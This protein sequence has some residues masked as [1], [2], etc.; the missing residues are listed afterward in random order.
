MAA[1]TFTG[2]SSPNDDI[3]V[4]VYDNEFPAQ[5]TTVCL[6]VNRDPTIYDH[7]YDYDGN[8]PNWKAT[9]MEIDNDIYTELSVVENK[10]VAG[11][12]L[13]PEP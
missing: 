13:P 11:T 12:E 7:G 2:E 8:I 10:Y 3:L 6:F 4:I 9:E 1:V 5:R